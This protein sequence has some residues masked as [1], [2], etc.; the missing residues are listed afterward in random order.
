MDIE[1]YGGAAMTSIHDELLAD[2][3]ALLVRR[4][5]VER[6]VAREFRGSRAALLVQAAQVERQRDQV[7]EELR[8]VVTDFDDAGTD[9][10]GEEDA[11]ADAFYSA[12]E[13]L[14]ARDRELVGAVAALQ[15]RAGE[16]RAAK[17]PPK[18]IELSREL[19]QLES[20]LRQWRGRCRRVGFAPTLPRWGK[21][22][23]GS[24]E[25]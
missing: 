15:R 1:T 19:E 5:A 10:D 25:D 14:V 8:Q 2:G 6:M 4:E 11:G 21:Y 18:L 22:A 7:R 12:R 17:V 13:R 23:G 9:D 20:Q 16:L 3:E 24:D